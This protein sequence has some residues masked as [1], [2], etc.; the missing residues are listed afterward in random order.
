MDAENLDFG[1][2]CGWWCQGQDAATGRR[3][4]RR[5]CATRAQEGE[6]AEESQLSADCSERRIF[7]W[8]CPVESSK[9]VLAPS[10]VTVTAAPPE[11]ASSEAAAAAQGD[12]MATALRLRTTQD[13]STCCPSRIP[14]RANY[15]SFAS[16]V[17][18]ELPPIWHDDELNTIIL[19]LPDGAQEKSPEDSTS[20]PRELRI[21]VGLCAEIEAAGWDV[22][23]G[24]YKPEANKPGKAVIFAEASPVSSSAGLQPKLPLSQSGGLRDRSSTS[25]S[26]LLPAGLR[27]FKASICRDVWGAAQVHSGATVAV[28]IPKHISPPTQAHLQGFCLCHPPDVPG[29]ITLSDGSSLGLLQLIR[30]ATVSSDSMSWTQTGHTSDTSALPVGSWVY[31]GQARA[32]CRARLH[33]V[34]L[35][36]AFV[37]EGRQEELRRAP[38]VEC[39]D[40]LARLLPGARIWPLHDHLVNRLLLFNVARTRFVNAVECVRLDRGQD[41]MDIVRLHYGE[42]T[43]FLM[44]WQAHYMKTLA[45]AVVLTIPFIFSKYT[46]IVLYMLP[47]VVLMI[48]F[49]V[50]MTELWHVH[51][52]WLVRRW[53]AH[54]DTVSRWRQI[55]LGMLYKKDDERHARAREQILSVEDSSPTS[56]APDTSP[57]LSRWVESSLRAACEDYFPRTPAAQS[58]PRSPSAPLPLPRSPVTF[59]EAISAS[60]FHSE[61]TLSPSQCPRSPSGASLASTCSLDESARLHCIAT[62]KEL[63]QDYFTPPSRL[64]SEKKLLET[65]LVLSK[66]V[67]KAV[68][69]LPI[70]LLQWIIITLFFTAIVWFEMWAIFD[71]GGCHETNLGKGEWTCLS[72]DENRGYAGIVVGA[73]PSICEGALFELILGLSKLVASLIIRCHSFSTRE[74]Q[75]FA[76]VV[77]VFVL[78]VCGKVGFI[79]VLAIAFVPIWHSNNEE[80]CEMMIDYYL[81][82]RLSLG[83]MKAR[84][85]YQVR[86]KILESA[87][88][89]P[90]LVSGL[91][92]IFV[93]TLFPLFLAAC[94]RCS[95]RNRPGGGKCDAC[96]RYQLMRIFLAPH[97][98]LLR[99]ATLLFQADGSAVGGPTMLCKWPPTTQAEHSHLLDSSR[100]PKVRAYGFGV[101][102]EGEPEALSP[103]AFEE[104]RANA[105]QSHETVM[106]CRLWSALQEGYRKEHEPFNEYLELLLHMLWTSSFAIVWPMGCVFALMN[107]LLEYRF[108]CLKLLYVRR[109]QFPNTRHMSVA[110]VPVCA[111]IVC[112]VAIVVNVALVLIPYRL[113][114]GHDDH[115]QDMPL[116]ESE[117]ALQVVV[118]LPVACAGFFLFRRGCVLLLNRLLWQGDGYPRFFKNHLKGK[119]GQCLSSLGM[120]RAAAQAFFEQ[121]PFGDVAPD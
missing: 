44:A 67:A 36:S 9:M 61:T 90:M 106:K 26:C 96:C 114:K 62:L 84:I 22:L 19:T 93:K 56:E 119:H 110:W 32:L 51:A 54:G 28:V 12:A 11:S 101:S 95:A 6:Q 35:L 86:L 50:A 29:W 63:G 74:K 45:P 55:V 107:M 100:P 13:A 111:E 17:H 117:F 60:R 8:L 34:A 87:M 79:L 5:T 83:C 7:P 37:D 99:V 47:Q 46:G 115:T 118:V 52:F 48:C 27:S 71:W 81:L 82:G 2:G 18:K 49:G 16:E 121:A 33:V 24:G 77:I 25:A 76:Y 109:R 80:G 102:Q 98:F 104:A 3:P 43:S 108:D 72:A 88:K 70:L 112:H 21:D 116:L 68:L 1:P 58:A 23:E 113:L 89:G 97:D 20:R 41:F 85:P 4:G 103:E 42:E 10:H 120:E 65:L 15:K 73:L 75:D 31:H 38:Q 57:N 69:L 64:T 91:V 53:H 30:K 78:E 66:N 105:K 40:V 39:H 14:A 59:S 92:G 94:R